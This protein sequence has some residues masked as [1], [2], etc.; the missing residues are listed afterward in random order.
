MNTIQVRDSIS[1]YISHNIKPIDTKL[2]EENALHLKS[3]IRQIRD[4]TTDSFVEVMFKYDYTKS[5]AENNDNTIK[6]NL[7][8]LYVYDYFKLNLIANFNSY[9]M[10]NKCVLLDSSTEYVDF[11]FKGGN[12]L[13]VYIDNLI[14]T[15]NLFR[16]I[17]PEYIDKINVMFNEYFKPS[18][19][20]F[21]VYLKTDTHE[22]FLLIKRYLIKFLINK[23]EEINLFFNSYL[24]DI[25]NNSN[26]FNSKFKNGTNIFIPNI[27]IL[28]PE[29]S[30]LEQE[31]PLFA[32]GLT[33]LALLSQPDVPE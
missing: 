21:G 20:D 14:K 29:I 28:E 15:N 23:L 8:L 13:F 6:R 22:K 9:L 2:I 31:I 24:T 33:T 17:N 25:F 1:N 19:F 27:P 5:I 10:E 3:K 4:Q 11:L 7:F 12:I 16:D 32:N 18:D 30:L 26:I